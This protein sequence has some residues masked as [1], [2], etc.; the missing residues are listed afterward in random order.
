MYTLIM[1]VA[2]WNGNATYGGP[3]SVDNFKTEKECLAF[4]EDYAKKLPK[5]F[6]RS[7]LM[8]NTRNSVEH[9]TCNKK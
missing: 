4:A 6:E 8:A 9:V 7:L 2:I 1:I 3:V 5:S